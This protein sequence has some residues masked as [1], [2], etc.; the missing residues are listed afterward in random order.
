VKEEDDGVGDSQ[1]D[2]PDSDHVPVGLSFTRSGRT[3]IKHNDQDRVRRGLKDSHGRHAS[4][5]GDLRGGQ[6]R[7]SPGLKRL[8]VD[9]E[10][11]SHSEPAIQRIMGY[12]I[13][14]H[15]QTATTPKGFSSTVLHIP[16]TKEV[17]ITAV[18]SLNDSDYSEQSVLDK[19]INLIIPANTMVKLKITMIISDT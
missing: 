6:T 10:E 13:D 4:T 7:Q 2:E 9:D 16:D 3:V 11:P 1:E 12:S 8:R 14:L 5:D 17:L 18:N 15:K 19:Q